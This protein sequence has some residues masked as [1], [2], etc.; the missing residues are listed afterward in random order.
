[1]REHDRESLYHRCD[2]DRCLGA[3]STVSLLQLIRK[4]APNIPWPGRDDPAVAGFA[5][6]PSNKSVSYVMAPSCAR[7]GALSQMP[8]GVPP[9]LLTVSIVP[10]E[11]QPKGPSRWPAG[12]QWQQR[13]LTTAQP[14]TEAQTARRWTAQATRPG[15]EVSWRV[16]R[17]RVLPHGVGNIVAAARQRWESFRCAA[18]VAGSQNPVTGKALSRCM[19]QH[20]PRAIDVT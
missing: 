4:T 3:S 2:Q 11:P 10:G 5:P 14:G 13:T 6:L 9:G 7:I 17:R 16:T 12:V 1:L 20:A 18:G 15:K 19:A 8:C